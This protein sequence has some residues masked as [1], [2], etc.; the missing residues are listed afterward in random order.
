MVKRSRKRL[1]QFN[2][3]HRG[4]GQYCHRCIRV[5]EPS[6]VPVMTDVVV[7]RPKKAAF[8]N[9]ARQQWRQSFA[10]DPIDL[11]HLPKPIAIRV[12]HILASLNQ[13]VAPRLM[14][15]KRFNFAL[16]RRYRKGRTLLRIPVS[17]RY[18]LL[19][20]WQSGQIIPLQVLSHE[21]YNAVSRNKK[22]ALSQKRSQKG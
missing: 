4:F 3:G 7:Y 2:C 8:K 18:R 11:T 9:T 10:H 20:R 16:L 17:C 12:R 1:N 5:A 21:S 14:Q 13:G 19:C 22:G 15:G 6:Q